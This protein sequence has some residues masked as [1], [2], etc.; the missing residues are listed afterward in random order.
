MDKV[1]TTLFIKRKYKYL[2]IIQIQVDDII[3]GATN[4]SFCEKFANVMNME[5]EMSMMG[6]LTFILGLKMK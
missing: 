2:L 3:F 6:E 1:N 5:F 4:E